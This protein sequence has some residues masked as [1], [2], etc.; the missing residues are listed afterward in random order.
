MTGITTMALMATS[1][2]IFQKGG[3]STAAM[4]T[5]IAMLL[6]GGIFFA[7]AIATTGGASV[8]GPEVCVYVCVCAVL[9]LCMG[10][11]YVGVGV[12]LCWTS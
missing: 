5:P 9:S 1:K 2:F 4:V 6:S 3:W 11:S 8:F 7:S 12:A 10:L